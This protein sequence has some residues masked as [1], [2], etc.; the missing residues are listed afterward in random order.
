MTNRACNASLIRIW[1]S[2]IAMYVNGALLMELPRGRLL[3]DLA[4]SDKKE[5]I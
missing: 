3:Q 2:I 5:L 4:D 1:L